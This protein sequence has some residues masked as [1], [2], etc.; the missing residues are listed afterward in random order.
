M[1][2]QWGHRGRLVFEASGSN[3]GF[4]GGCIDDVEIC[5]VG[6]TT[7]TAAAG[8]PSYIYNENVISIPTPISQLPN[9]KKSTF[10]G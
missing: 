1:L 3:N 2:T 5:K 10:V 6:Q 9:V 4:F 8:P 7:S